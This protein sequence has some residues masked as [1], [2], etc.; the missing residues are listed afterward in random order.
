MQSGQF[1]TFQSLIPILNLNAYYFL[2]QVPLLAYNH[3]VESIFFLTDCPAPQH[4]SL[5]LSQQSLS[6]AWTRSQLGAH[7]GFP[8]GSDMHRGKR[9]SVY[10]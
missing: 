3:F 6:Q 10:R 8:D 4:D 1:Q 2:Y 7:N 9:D 5:A